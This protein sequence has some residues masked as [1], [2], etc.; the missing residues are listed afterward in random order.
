MELNL[1]TIIQDK[2]LTLFPDIEA[3]ILDKIIV[4]RYRFTEDQ[5]AIRP[6][7]SGCRYNLESHATIENIYSYVKEVDPKVVITDRSRSYY[8]PRLAKL[9][10]QHFEGKIKCYTRP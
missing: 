10:E 4:E 6:F 5:P 2:I 7:S 1:I 9:I 3:D 8:A